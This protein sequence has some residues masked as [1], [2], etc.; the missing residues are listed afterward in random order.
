MRKGRRREDGAAAS[1]DGG[2]RGQ[3]G[4]STPV[5]SYDGFVGPRFAMMA[6]R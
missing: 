2:G 1:R 4:T 5:E 3:S 6:P